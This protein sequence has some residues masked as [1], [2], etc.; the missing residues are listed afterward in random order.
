MSAQSKGRTRRFWLWA[1]VVIV[2][3]A[4][5]GA[6]WGL[7]S[8]RALGLEAPAGTVPEEV[9]PALSE[10]SEACCSAD[11]MRW[12]RKAAK[13]FRAG[14]IH[15]D[16]GMRPGDIYR[17]PG[18]ARRIWINKIHRWIVTHPGHLR[19]LSP[20]TVAGRSCQ[21]V[22]YCYAAGVYDD[23]VQDSTCV[24]GSYPA[25]TQ[26]ACDRAPWRNGP[27]LTKKQ[28][29]VGGALVLCGAGVAMSVVTAPPSGGS[30]VALTAFLGAATCGWAFWA[31]VD[32]G[33][34]SW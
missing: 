21:P 22:D 11:V 8:E 12:A 25:A 17:A 23:A 6:G 2:V 27:G 19:T 5:L 15:R 32:G 10:R 29:Q 7:L 26:G 3:M 9:Q 31:S 20:R 18:K 13:K 24:T 33:G 16:H 4:L 28:V 30:S 1:I 14:K 34:G